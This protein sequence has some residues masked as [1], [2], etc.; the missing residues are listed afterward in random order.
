MIDE[1]SELLTGWG[2]HAPPGGWLAHCFAI[3]VVVIMAVIANVIAKRVILRAA[4][5]S[6]RH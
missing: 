1:I 3:S 6:W 2:F 4:T 5:G